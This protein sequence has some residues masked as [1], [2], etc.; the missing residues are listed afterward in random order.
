MDLDISRIIGS[1]TGYT[2]MAGYCL[3]S[4]ISSNNHEVIIITGG[5]TKIDNTFYH[6]V[7]TVKLIE[8]TD[9]FIKEREEKQRIEQEAL[10]KIE[11][12][13]K[14]KQNRLIKIEENKLYVNRTLIIG[15]IFI[16]CLIIINA[17]KP[18]K[19]KVRK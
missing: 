14:L 8:Y 19:K 1:K 12:Q 13:E 6:L 15:G 16:F 11:E 5:A 9:E 18:K 7:D 3:S 17:C 2:S 10:K 4:L